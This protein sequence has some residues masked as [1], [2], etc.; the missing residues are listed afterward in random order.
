MKH[1]FIAMLAALALCAN[2]AYAGAAAKKGDDYAKLA[3][4]FEKATAMGPELLAGT[5]FM[6]Y[7]SEAVSSAEPKKKFKETAVFVRYCAA[8]CTD[9]DTTVRVV[10]AGP[11]LTHKEAKQLLRNKKN[12]G[13]DTQLALTATGYIGAEP[14]LYDFEVRRKSNGALVYR[15]T[16]AKTGNIVYALLTELR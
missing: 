7:K 4:M 8:Q 9:A 10:L 11:G 15:R 3:A 1:L 16:D 2:S 14:G 5:V 6:V 12:P 13:I